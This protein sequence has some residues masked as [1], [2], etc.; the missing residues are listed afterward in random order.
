MDRNLENIIDEAI[1]YQDSVEAIQALSF[2]KKDPSQEVEHGKF[3]QLQYVRMNSLSPFKVIEL[4]KESITVAYTIPDFDLGEKVKSYI[5]L[6]DDTIGEMKFMKD[7]VALLK[8]SEETLGR[9]NIVVNGTPS[10][11]TIGLWLKDYLTIHTEDG[12]KNAFTELQYMNTSENTKSLNESEKNI[13]KSLLKLI[14]YCNDIIAH[15]DSIPTPK[16]DKEAFQEYD[17][18]QFI[19]GVEIDEDSNEPDVY[20]KEP[21][22]SEPVKKPAPTP[23]LVNDV[24]QFE[25]KKPEPVRPKPKNPVHLT[26]S[27]DLDDIIGQIPRQKMGVVKDPTNIKIADEELR[28]GHEKNARENQIQRKLAEL[29]NRNN[30]P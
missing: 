9:S 17:L 15:W 11:P 21:P 14:D 30:K 27:S 13:L 7:L 19:P 23:V 2:I 5:D 20:V 24:E 12:I 8:T 1:A 26:S 10:K 3:L 18:Y 22:K 6:M 25:V 28:L 16:T 4:L 29:R